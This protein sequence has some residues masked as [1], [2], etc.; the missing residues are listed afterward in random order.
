M[1]RIEPASSMNAFIWSCSRPLE[2]KDRVLAPGV[3]KRLDYRYVV[4]EHLPL[5]V[6]VIMT[7]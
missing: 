3:F 7:V 5:A 2:E 6:G 4:D 1:E